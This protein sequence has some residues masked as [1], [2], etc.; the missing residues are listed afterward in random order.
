MPADRTDR[1]RA[2]SG[3]LHGA[4][5]LQRG[6]ARL[7]GLGDGVGAVIRSAVSAGKKVRVLACETR[8]LLQGARLTAGSSRD[9]IEVTVVTDF[10][11]AFLMRQ[12]EVDLVIVGADRITKDAVFNKIGTV[13]ARRCARHHGIPFYVAAPRSS[14]DVTHLAR[15]VTIEGAGSCRDRLLRQH[16][17]DA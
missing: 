4:H 16:G 1:C 15:E 10:G 9:G 11:A 5:S 17:D 14:F 6:S 8:P 3:L 12:G 13:H 2:S 7:P